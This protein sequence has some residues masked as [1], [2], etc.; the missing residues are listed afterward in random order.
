MKK[1]K[2]KAYFK[3]SVTSYTKSLPMV[4]IFYTLAIEKD[5]SY[6]INF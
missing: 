5:K 6:K 3:L 1:I 4:K 2:I